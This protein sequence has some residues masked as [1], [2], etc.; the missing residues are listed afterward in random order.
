MVPEHY[1]KHFIELVKD[2]YEK[3][4]VNNNHHLFKRT[5]FYFLSASDINLYDV[6][7]F[8]ERLC[9]LETFN[10]WRP[11]NEL[12]TDEYLNL[13]L[14]QEDNDPRYLRD[15]E[16]VL[17]HLQMSHMNANQIIHHPVGRVW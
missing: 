17:R 7:E 10:M 4:Q 16:R 1:S 6:K 12:N 13:G 11:P 15:I 5:Q 2:G 8:F 14:C 3:L 9:S